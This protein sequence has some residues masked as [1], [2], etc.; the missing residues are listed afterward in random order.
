MEA[1]GNSPTDT[2]RPT[3]LERRL[4]LRCLQFCY[5]CAECVQIREFE[6]LPYVV[7]HHGKLHRLNGAHFGQSPT[8]L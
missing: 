5:S 2:R 3:D 8:D 4:H 6:E 1:S 7:S